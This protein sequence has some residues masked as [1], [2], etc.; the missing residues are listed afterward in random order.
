[1]FNH[2]N[3]LEIWILANQII[4]YVSSIILI[5]FAL[6]SMWGMESR[7][8]ALLSLG[9]LVMGILM[10]IFAYFVAMIFAVLEA[11]IIVFG[12]V[13]TVLTILKVERY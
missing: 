12:I 3:P 6:G 11:V 9:L 4:V 5:I 2:L 7:F 13:T 8:E 10:W 1:M